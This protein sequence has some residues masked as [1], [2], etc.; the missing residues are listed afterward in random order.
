[1]MTGGEDVGQI[2][3]D[4]CSLGF[5]SNTF[6]AQSQMNQLINSN[7]NLSMIA[8]NDTLGKTSNFFNLKDSEINSQNSL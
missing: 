5:P 7:D 2:S 8:N 1:M 6:L 4:H 3:I